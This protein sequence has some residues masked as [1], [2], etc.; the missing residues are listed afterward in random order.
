[1]FSKV[2]QSIYNGSLAT[3]GPWEAMVTFQQFLV[4]S[5]KFGDVDMTADVIARRTIIPLEIIE[6][7]IAELSKPDPLSRDKTAEGR[8]IVLINPDRPWGWHIV[9]YTKYS[10]IRNAE[11]RRE[12]KA[13]YYREKVAPRIQQ[14]KQEPSTGFN[15]FWAACPRKVG[16]GS[17]EKAWRKIAPDEALTMQIVKAMTEQRTCEQWTRDGGKF[18]PHPATWLNRK[19]WLDEPQAEVDYGTCHVCPAK[20]VGRSKSGLAHCAK[21]R[22]IDQANGR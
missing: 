11:E 9:N 17:A 18:I 21:A 2:F 6:K 19:G 5:D 4:L 13:A 16:K 7:G 22:H 10:A 15:E 20:A 1:M 14:D 12:Y 8:R 3:V